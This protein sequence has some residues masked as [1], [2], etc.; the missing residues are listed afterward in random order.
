[1]GL[2]LLESSP[3][4]SLGRGPVAGGALIPNQII[5]LM[6]NMVVKGESQAETMWVD[7]KGEKAVGCVG[8][9]DNQPLAI[10]EMRPGMWVWFRPRHV[11][12]IHPQGAARRH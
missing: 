2:R 5:K 8:V 12:N 7:V 3:G 9:L 6:F 1:M 10:E 4:G 11:I